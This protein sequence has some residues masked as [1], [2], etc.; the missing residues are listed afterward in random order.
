MSA[1]SRTLRSISSFGSFR[2]FSPNAML[3][4]T[5]MCGYSA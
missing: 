5:V 3:S 1:A 4:Y 2:S